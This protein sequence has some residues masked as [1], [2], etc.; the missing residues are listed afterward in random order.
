M[1]KEIDSEGVKAKVTNGILTV[2][3]PIC[4]KTENTVTVE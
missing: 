4:T 2:T 3:L 1:P